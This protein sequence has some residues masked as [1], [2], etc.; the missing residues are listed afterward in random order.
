MGWNAYVH[1]LVADTRQ[2][3]NVP[4]DDDN[5][6][7]HQWDDLVNGCMGTWEAIVTVGSLVGQPLDELEAVEQ[8]LLLGDDGLDGHEYQNLEVIGELDNGALDLQ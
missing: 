3:S 8:E 5:R 6:L 1:D 2:Y 4:I 7:L